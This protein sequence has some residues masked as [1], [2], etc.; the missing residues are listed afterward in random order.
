MCI[1]QFNVL[2]DLLI[3]LF[4]FFFLIAYALKEFIEVRDYIIY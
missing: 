3:C 4:F 2:L 1:T